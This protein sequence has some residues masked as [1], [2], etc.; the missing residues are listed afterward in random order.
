LKQSNVIASRWTVI[1]IVVLSVF[2]SSCTTMQP[3]YDTP[4]VNLSSFRA[5]PSEGAVPS[6]EIGLQV[7]NP[8]SA[9]LNLRGVAYTIRLEGHDLIKGVSNELPVIDA[10]GQGQFT[11]TAS[12]SLF[13]GI[14]LIMDL[15]SGPKDMFSYELE[16]KLDIGAFQPAIRIRDSGE[17]SLRSSSHEL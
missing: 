14:R 17:I 12:A 11:V 9:P 3:D 16:A 5:L 7:I 2:L 8:N 13:A 6:F 15:M 4:T 1:P 10:Y